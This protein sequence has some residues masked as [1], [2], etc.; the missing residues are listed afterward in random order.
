MTATKNK[1]NG[2]FAIPIIICVKLVTTV[3][4]LD[5]KRWILFKTKGY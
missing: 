5:K 3:C 4:V 2:L 1:A